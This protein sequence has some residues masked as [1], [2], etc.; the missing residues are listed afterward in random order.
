MIYE[1]LKFFPA[2]DRIIEIELG[3]EM[4]FKLNFLAHS[5]AKSI[6]E[7]HIDGFVELITELASLQIVYDPEKISFINLKKEINSIFCDLGNLDNQELNSRIYYIPVLYFDPWTQKCI[8]AY[9]LGN[10]IQK[11]NDADLIVKLN[12]LSDREELKRIHSGT[13]YWVAALGFWPGLC[14]LIPLDPRFKLTAPKY[15][16]PRLWTPKGAIGL[17]GSITS[18]YPDCTPGG[19]QIFGITPSPTYDA[20]QTLPDFSESLA[21]IR[22]GDRVRFIPIELN[23]YLHIEKEVKLGVFQHNYSDYQKFSILNYNK[24]IKALKPPEKVTKNGD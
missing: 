23:E 17:G 18:I 5:L 13:D 16:P 14:S 6:K 3:N 10:K 24:W 8:D 9:C 11:E 19:Y 4:S 20:T 2:G 22:A 1:S 12:N 7:A 21:L 15:N